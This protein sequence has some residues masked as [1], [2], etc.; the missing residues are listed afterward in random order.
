MLFV[1]YQ[2][3]GICTYPDLAVMFLDATHDWRTG[4]VD[5]FVDCLYD[6]LRLKQLRWIAGLLACSRSDASAAA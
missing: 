1:S 3:Q 4:K 5:N 6:S 2:G